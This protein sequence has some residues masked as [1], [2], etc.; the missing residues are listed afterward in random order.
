MAHEMTVTV[1]NKKGKWVNV[2]SRRRLKGKIV[3][4]TEAEIRRS[5]NRKTIKQYGSVKDAVAAARKRSK[6]SK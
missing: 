3:R 1:K 5:S 6:G 4:F 2:P